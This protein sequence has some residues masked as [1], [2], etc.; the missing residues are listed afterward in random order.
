MSAKPIVMLVAFTASI[1]AADNN[2]T[3]T[4]KILQEQIKKQMALEK[5]YAKEQRF[6]QGD[7]YD[8][9]SKEINPEILKNIQPIEPDYDHTNDWGAADS[10]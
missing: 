3:Q 7:A 4:K 1:F 6:Y 10:E 2:T 8:L 9:K 5:K